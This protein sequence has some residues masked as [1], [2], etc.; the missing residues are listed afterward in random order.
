MAQRKKRPPS[1]LHCSWNSLKQ[2]LFLSSFSQFGMVE[3]KTL[4]PIT[5]SFFLALVITTLNRLGLFK[6]PDVT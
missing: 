5:M 3:K 2:A 6:N 4:L 1:F